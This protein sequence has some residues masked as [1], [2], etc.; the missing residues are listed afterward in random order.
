MNIFMLQLMEFRVFSNIQFTFT[1]LKQFNLAHEFN[2]FEFQKYLGLKKKL[3]NNKF[4]I[5]CIH[6]DLCSFI[7]LYIT[8]N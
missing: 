8:K 4:G 3:F 5:K 1:S 6:F 7:L 2:R